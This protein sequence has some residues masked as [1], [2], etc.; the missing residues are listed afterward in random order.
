MRE[1]NY[2][3]LENKVVILISKKRCV[4]TGNGIALKKGVKKDGAVLKIKGIIIPN[5]INTKIYD[6]LFV[7]EKSVEHLPFYN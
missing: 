2:N 7:S 5:E 3:E 4:F 1:C 6:V